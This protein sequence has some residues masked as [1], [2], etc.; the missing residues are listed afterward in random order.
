M[1]HKYSRVNKELITKNEANFHYFAPQTV[2]L[3][4]SVQNNIKTSLKNTLLDKT[5]SSMRR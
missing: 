1:E 3:I 2:A 4:Y 5:S